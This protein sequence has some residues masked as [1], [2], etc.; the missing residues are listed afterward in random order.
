VPAL[1]LAGARVRVDLVVGAPGWACAGGAERL[2]G[3]IC[4]DGHGHS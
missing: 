4:G 1:A 2:A 3:G